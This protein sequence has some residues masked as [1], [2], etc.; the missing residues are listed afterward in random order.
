MNSHGPH[1]H[2][3]YGVGRVTERG[4][5]GP[6]CQCSGGMK[7]PRAQERPSRDVTTAGRNPVSVF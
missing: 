4:S 3:A 7:G 2:A 1:F 6:Y 5:P